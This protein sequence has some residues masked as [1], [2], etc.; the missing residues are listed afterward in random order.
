MGVPGEIWIAG[1]GVARGYLDR[2]ELTAER[3]AE[4]GG[5]RA[6]RTGDRAR[7][8]PDGV[9]EFLGRTDEQVKIRG[10]RVEP[11]EIEATLLTHPD[12]ARAAVMLR[13]DTPGDQRLVA[14]TVPAAADARCEG[15]REFL[16]GRL[17]EH[18]I[19]AAVITL[20]ELPL[21]GNGKLDRK[22][23]PA[24]GGNEATGSPRGGA[25]S[26][27]EG[28]VAEVFAEILGRPEVG[29]DEDFFQLGG[30]SLLGTRLIS[31]LQDMFQVAVP[32]RRIF[33]SP[34]VAGLAEIIELARLETEE[35]EK[36]HVL[37]MLAQLADDEID[38]ELAKRLQ[39]T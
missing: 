10:F 26:A 18:M 19:P 9:L 28:L 13:E 11:G 6:Y 35:A 30:H 34:T 8:R 21:T 23:L 24:P 4:V 36:K 12:V 29:V 15:L 33:E 20:D 37:L 5:E 38:A 7:W 22:A 16:A 32:L 31:R 2:P 27:L 14:Y 17:P 1:G 25:A 39:S 3:F